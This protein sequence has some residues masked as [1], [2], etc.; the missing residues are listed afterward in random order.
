LG[1][2]GADRWASSVSDSDAVMAGRLAR[3]RGW[4]GVSVEL[5]RTWRKWPTMIFPIHILFPT[6]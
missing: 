6:E 3:A 2:D 5:G 4:A 1:E